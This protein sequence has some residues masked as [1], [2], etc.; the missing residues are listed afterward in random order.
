MDH[1]ML[2]DWS[3]ILDPHA[4]SWFRCLKITQQMQKCSS[5]C[6]WTGPKAL[7]TQR[8]P[9]I[10]KFFAF[11]FISQKNNIIFHDVSW[12][13]NK[14]IIFCPL[15]VPWFQGMFQPGFCLFSLWITGSFGQGLHPTS[16]RRKMGWDATDGD[17]SLH[18]VFL[19]FTHV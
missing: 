17:A 5:K 3:F 9:A 11:F 15:D 6:L 8:L 2:S 16:L 19:E 14:S 12:C 13:S 4:L 10:A 1:K 18:H 7:N